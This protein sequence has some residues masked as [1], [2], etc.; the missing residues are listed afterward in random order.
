VIVLCVV[1]CVGII[2]AGIVG[3][4]TA[5]WQP[6]LIAAVVVVVLGATYLLARAVVS[7]GQRS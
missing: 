3:V 2:V 6:L 5:A 4:V 7:K 1:V